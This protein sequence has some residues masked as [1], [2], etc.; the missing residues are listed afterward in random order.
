MKKFSIF[1]F[2]TIAVLVCGA[3]CS[4]QAQSKTKY[5]YGEDKFESPTA[6]SENMASAVSSNESFRDCAELGLAT[7]SFEA[8]EIDLNHDGIA[9]VVVKGECGNSATSYYYW[10]LRKHGQ[11]YGTILFHAAMGFEILDERSNEWPNIEFSGCNANTCF[12]TDYM[13]NEGNYAITKSFEKPV[14]T[15]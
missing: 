13:F 6:I 12:Y 11:K 5:F 9:E 7:G 4:S 1:E 14:D 3:A 15:P 10:V 2:F 8:S